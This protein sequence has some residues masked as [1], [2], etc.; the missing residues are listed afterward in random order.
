MHKP[1]DSAIMTIFGITGDLA[2]R[3]LLPALYFLQR[4]NLLPEHF[5]IV[6]VTRRNA[7]VKDIMESLEARIKAMDT[8]C[9]SAI[10][11]QLGK[12]IQIVSMDLTSKDSYKTLKTT[13]DTIET[14]EGVCLNRL[15][16]LAIPSQVFEPV[17]KLLGEA[18]LHTGCQHHTAESRLLI[19]KPFGF[20]IDSAHELIEA[21]SV[22]FT[23]EQIYR[24]DHYLAKETVQNILTFREQNP[25]FKSSW[26]DQHIKRIVITATE[27]IGIEGRANFYEHMG[28][29][30]DL[31]QSHLLQLLA[32]VIMREPARTS[33]EAIHAA[34]LEALKSIV[35]PADDLMDTM[36]VRAQYEGYRDEVENQQS[37]TETFA[38]V[39][40]TVDTEGWRNIPIYVR[41]GKNLTAKDTEISIL[42]ANEGSPA[43][44]QLT[45]RIQPDEGIQL[46]ITIKKPGYEAA[47][48]IV[49]M[50]FRYEGEVASEHPD[51][52]ERVIID[53]LKGD[54]TLF[55]T[56]EEVMECW[57]IVQP[58][59]SAWEKNRVP[60]L[61]YKPGSSGPESGETADSFLLHLTHP[62]L[63]T[64][65]IITTQTSLG[66][67]ESN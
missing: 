2:H 11:K 44:N 46:G 58:I 17:V 45:I 26:N 8:P 62:R 50:A 9:D 15:F 18:K 65:P 59:L 21:L 42:F 24:I 64:L 4:D 10:L 20:D 7:K 32:L 37:N 16:Y 19:E 36:T 60:L 51:A 39:R 47:T 12:K 66:E 6:G 28:A 35:P 48:G 67:D 13:L 30:R 56:D 41:T 61:G 55:A 25:L 53:A 29:L 5:K 34:K 57:R 3:K 14:T 1:I 54:K 43:K 38:A 63:E 33:S 22:D 31:I 52:Y 23:E 49:H 27:K 40:L